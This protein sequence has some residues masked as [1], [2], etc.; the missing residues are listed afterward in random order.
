MWLNGPITRVTAKT[1]TFVKVRQH[2]LTG[3][4]QPVKI[5]DACM[6]LAEF[7]NGSMGTFESTRYARGRKNFNT[8]ELNGADGSVY[9]DLEEP[10]YLQYFEYKQLQ[11]GKKI[12]SHLTG[13]RKIHTTNSEHPYMNRYW[14]PGT[15]I[16]Y[17]HTF[18]N[19][20]A[21]FVMGI[22]SGRPAQPDFRTAL[23]TQ[24]VCDA[25]LKSA[26]TGR[27]V[28]TGVKL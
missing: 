11:S 20:L 5:D 21:D 10:E 24:R 9:F 25:V 16:G 19:A 1:E 4:K 23:Q 18:L 28:N 22:E 27:W 3:K 7:A 26:Q 8:F 17:E 15:C 2:V 12:E 14:V 6:F 13:W